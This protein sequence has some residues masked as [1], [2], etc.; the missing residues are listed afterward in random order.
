M[1]FVYKQAC[2]LYIHYVKNTENL[3]FEWYLWD[4]MGLEDKDGDHESNLIAS[5]KQYTVSRTCCSV[6]TMAS[7]PEELCFS[8]PGQMEIAES[9]RFPYTSIFQSRW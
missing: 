2:I 4:I 5:G 1:N 7:T 9:G 8:A 6:F 3:V